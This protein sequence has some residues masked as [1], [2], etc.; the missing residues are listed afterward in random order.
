MKIKDIRKVAGQVFASHSEVSVAYV[1]GSFVKGK[2]FN[3]VDI[4]LLLEKNF[5]PDALYEVRFAGQ[6]EKALGASFD[7]RILNDRPLRFLFHI[8]QDAKLIYVRDDRYRIKFEQSVLTQYMDIKPYHD[9]F[10]EHR[11]AQYVNR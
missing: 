9:M 6:F 11:R 2:I 1:F 7:I 3:D 10:E 5:Q 8:L 4:G